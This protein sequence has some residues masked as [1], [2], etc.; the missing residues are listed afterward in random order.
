MRRTRWLSALSAVSLIA[1][2]LLAAGGA[3]A[4]E[5]DEPQ[6]SLAITSP[7][8]GAE[9]QGDTVTVEGTFSNA[10][11]LVLVVGA[12]DLLPIEA[13]G[14]DGTWSIELDISDVDG[15]LDLAVRGRDLATLY[16]TWSP[17][18][19]IDV[20]NSAAS[21]PVRDD[22]VTRGWR[23]WGAPVEGR[24]GGRVASRDRACGG[25]RQRR[26]VASCTRRATPLRHV[27][28]DLPPRSRSSRVSKHE[29]WM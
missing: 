12:Q 13:T 14:M 2:G 16:T 28:C 19:A 22:R 18:I 29:R 17:F 15:R 4:A 8:D 23:A 11:E 24:R 25:A 10:S 3:Q 9:V 5:A 6:T 1:G 27:S 7:T 20:N 21:R 26:K